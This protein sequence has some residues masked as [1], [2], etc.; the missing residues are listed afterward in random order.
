M[1]ASDP[2]RL[3]DGQLADFLWRRLRLEPP[4]E[5]PLNDRFG[6]EAP[7]EFLI[8]AVERDQALRSR[9]IRAIRQNLR[10]LG[11]VQTGS[12]E[13]IWLNPTVDQQLA[14]LA[15]LASNLNATELVSTLEKVAWMWVLPDPLEPTDFSD[16]QFHVLRA[17]ARLQ[18]GDRLAKFWDD[19]WE[20]GPRS[21][22]P[23]AL[24][25]WARADASHALE[26]LGELIESESDT[27]LPT[28]MWAL[29]RPGGPG[30]GPV[31]DAVA[32]LPDDLRM[33]ARRALQVA[34]VDAA[35]LDEFDRRSA[36]AADGDEFP[37]SFEPYNRLAAKNPR[38]FVVLPFLALTAPRDDG[39]TAGPQS[40]P[41]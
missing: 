39:R 17:M 15:F 37:F 35:T 36:E 19:L 33:K 21:A 10:R 28:T 20:H 1:D 31:A 2:T 25:G 8:R 24:F 12:T 30:L 23:L 4:L 40:A 5:P 41:A 18:S 26:H 11:V 14:S 3:T 7:E 13:P 6:H 34:G 32:N 9:V 38:F 29:V 27:D 22:R 16:G